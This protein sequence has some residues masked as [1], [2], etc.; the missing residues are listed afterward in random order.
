MQSTP[1][2]LNHSNLPPHGELS[3]LK[4]LRESYSP[5]STLSTLSTLSTSSRSIISTLDNDHNKTNEKIFSP[6]ETQAFWFSTPMEGNEN[7]KF[8]LSGEIPKDQFVLGGKYNITIEKSNG[9][10]PL[11][12]NITVNVMDLL[13][14]EN[15]KTISIDP[16]K[17]KTLE[18]FSIS[19]GK[20][21]YIILTIEFSKSGDYNRDKCADP[22]STAP[23][24]SLILSSS[25]TNID[26]IKHTFDCPCWV[27][28][29]VLTNPL[30]NN[31]NDLS[32]ATVQYDPVYRIQGYPIGAKVHYF[33][34]EL[35]SNDNLSRIRITIPTPIWFKERQSRGFTSIGM[36]IQGIGFFTSYNYR[37]SNGCTVNGQDVEVFVVGM[38]TIAIIELDKMVINNDNDNVQMDLLEIICK[39]DSLAV[40][41]SQISYTTPIP[42][43][44]ALFPL[45]FIR[46][47]WQPDYMS[48]SIQFPINTTA[49]IKQGYLPTIKASPKIEP[50]SYHEV[51]P[52]SITVQNYSNSTAVTIF[53]QWTISFNGYYPPN[54]KSLKDLFQITSPILNPLLV[55]NTD[56]FW[57]SYLN[58][59]ELNQF[60]KDNYV[61]YTP[62]SNYGTTNLSPAYHADIQTVRLSALINGVKH[63]NGQTDG[64]SGSL[65][66]LKFHQSWDTD[67]L[68]AISLSEA[69]GKYNGKNNNNNS[70]IETEFLDILS[71]QFRFIRTNM[72]N[73]KYKPISVAI[74]ITGPTVYSW[75][76]TGGNVNIKCFD[77]NG[78][79]Q[80]NGCELPNASISPQSFNMTFVLGDNIAFIQMN[81]TGVHYSHAHDKTF[82]LPLSNENNHIDDDDDN[83]NDERKNNHQNHQN[84][85]DSPSCTKIT[86]INNNNNNNRFQFKFHQITSNSDSFPPPSPSPSPS[87]SSSSSSS[88]PSS[89]LN[90]FSTTAVDSTSAPTIFSIGFEFQGEIGWDRNNA[91]QWSH[92]VHKFHP[93]QSQALPTSTRGY[94]VGTNSAVV[95]Y[96][97]DGSNNNNG[98]SNIGIIIGIVVGLLGLIGIA[99]LVFFCLKKKKNNKSTKNKNDNDDN[100]ATSYAQLSTLST[101]YPTQSSKSSQFSE[102]PKQTI[103]NHHGVVYST[104]GGGG[105]QSS[106]SNAPLTSQQQQQHHHHQPPPPPSPYN[107]HQPPP[108]STIYPTTQNRSLQP[109]PPSAPYQQPPPPSA[110][111][112][113]YSPPEQQQQ[114][115]QQQYTETNHV[116][117]DGNPYAQPDNM[118]NY[119]PYH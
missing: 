101:E 60:G 21:F 71:P 33:E 70:A 67:D 13:S 104:S 43:N 68:R 118:E 119:N 56:V 95:D 90:D 40:L 44:L 14:L 102:P 35:A 37:H 106:Y 28:K 72:N 7:K 63:D 66:H 45:K 100:N 1:S 50:S 46:D 16:I 53:C 88:S 34:L 36:K 79:R 42:T 117:N 109:P 64:Y 97:S 22:L 94:I 92:I 31:R 65:C 30:L 32:I 10:F 17:L 49:Y 8:I 86:P 83:G 69:T 82:V 115:Q 91:Q 111:H 78:K 26:N 93:S 81:T 112:S 15:L 77:K 98:S 39:T 116:Y 57:S 74:G 52:N 38:N 62:I 61:F 58:T 89:P 9:I 103:S 20:H 84:N 5:P 3:T 85:C 75:D 87:P 96:D 51:L 110:P 23:T 107:H 73:D 12:N 25:T 4:A 80:N 108:P 59:Y 113:V 19:T 24:W 105:N 11:I 55:S 114:Q 6:Q 47:S 41:S 76:D 54:Y 18:E 27:P 48:G 2:G 99:C 29:T